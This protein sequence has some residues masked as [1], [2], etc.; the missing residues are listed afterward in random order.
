MNSLILV[1]TVFLLCLGLAVAA[2]LLYTPEQP[3]EERRL[4]PFA[5]LPVA[6]DTPSLRA[7]LHELAAQVSWMDAA[8]LHSVILVYPEDAP[9]L[10]E[11]CEEAAQ[12]YEVFM[13][14]SLPQM[15]ALLESR[16]RVT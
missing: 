8:V 2:A 14:M 10:R 1:G 6:E 11:L 5:V 4:T 3:Q 15:E 12:N 16:T 13:A 9:A 7:F